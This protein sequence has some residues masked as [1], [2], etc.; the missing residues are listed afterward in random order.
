[1]ILNTHIPPTTTVITL[2]CYHSKTGRVTAST[3]KDATK[4]QLQATVSHQL[5][6]DTLLNKKDANIHVVKSHLTDPTAFSDV[7]INADVLLSELAASPALGQPC[8]KQSCYTNNINH[9]VIDCL[10]DDIDFNDLFDSEPLPLAKDN[11]LNNQHKGSRDHKGSCDHKRSCD[12]D[13][14]CD[15]IEVNDDTIIEVPE[16]DDDDDVTD[17]SSVSCS[18]SLYKII[19]PCFNE[20]PYGEKFSKL[21]KNP[22]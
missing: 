5:K 22:P 21:L 4:S 14:L 12:H 15:I 9:N 7:N 1:M 2:M 3:V 16:T 11:T 13:M 18:K 19:S 6:I 17:M 20:L 8:H 10:F